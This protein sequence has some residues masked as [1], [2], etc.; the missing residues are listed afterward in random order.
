M[1]GDTADLYSRIAI[2]VASGVI[3]NI[4]VSALAMAG[5]WRLILWRIAK[6]EEKVGQHNG[7]SDRVARLEATSYARL[8]ATSYAHRRQS[9]THREEQ[10]PHAVS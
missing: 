8:E 9:D 5:S 6:L 3:L 7:F 1:T 2:I 4:V 10:A